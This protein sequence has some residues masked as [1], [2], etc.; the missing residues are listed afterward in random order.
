MLECFARFKTRD[1]NVED[2]ERLGQSKKLE[3][4]ELEAVLDQ[5]SCQMQQ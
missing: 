3:D 5:D 2:K 4:G 1:F